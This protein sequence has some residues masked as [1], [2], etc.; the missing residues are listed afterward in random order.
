MPVLASE[1]MENGTMNEYLRKEEAADILP[2]VRATTVFMLSLSQTFYAQI[3]GIARG[4]EY[5]HSLG[6]VHGDL[7]GVR[8]I[9]FLFFSNIGH[10]F[11]PMI[12]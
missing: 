2:L 1:W 7:R 9:I 11:L 3:Q 8:A 12:V 5:L 6:V 10:L 4:V